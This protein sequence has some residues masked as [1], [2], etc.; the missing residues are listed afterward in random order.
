MALGRNRSRS[1]CSARSPL[2][3]AREL[4]A[5][6]C[7]GI[8]TSTESCRSAEDKPVLGDQNYAR[9]F[10]SS[11]CF[12]NRCETSKSEVAGIRAFANDNT[13]KMSLT[14]QVWKNV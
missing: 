4:A 10:S 14:T 5:N 12:S 13:G 2:P 1:F 7:R 11:Q 9:A 3:A 8:E 6:R